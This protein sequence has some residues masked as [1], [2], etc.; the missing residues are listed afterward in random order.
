MESEG[1]GVVEVHLRHG[2]I[3]DLLSVRT[4]ASSKSA[5]RDSR[6]GSVGSLASRGWPCCHRS[7][8]PFPGTGGRGQG[9]R[10]V[11][12]RARC[13]GKS[14]FSVGIHERRR[15]VAL[16]GK[17]SPIRLPRRRPAL[18]PLA[19]P[20]EFRA[21]VHKE[22]AFFERAYRKEN[23]RLSSSSRGRACS[24]RWG[25][26]AASGICAKRRACSTQWSPTM[27]PLNTL[28]QEST[29]LVSASRH[30]AICQ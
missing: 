28:R 23:Y 7:Q 11:S 29:W 17:M 27:R 22:P 8:P 15:G 18:L 30:S 21:A 19:V 6:K 9:G 3:L 26:R 2:S 5:P 10:N 13:R 14:T 16:D 1:Q 25:F 12:S 20:P 4:S 24:T